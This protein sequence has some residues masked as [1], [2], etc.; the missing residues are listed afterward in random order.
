MRFI[1]ADLHKQ[2][3]TLCVVELVKGKTVI[4]DRPRFR[5]RDIDRIAEFLRAQG[6]CALVV[7]ST[8][9]YE[10]FVGLAEAIV[11]RVAVAHAA[12]LKIIAESTRKTDK[13]DAYVLAE[14][15]AKDM[16]PEAWFPTP[17][18]RQHR[19]LVR[20]AYK[21]KSRITSVKNTIRGILTRYNADRRDAFTRLGWEALQRVKMLDEDRWVLEDLREDLAELR[22][23]KQKV[24]K[25]LAE[26]AAQ[27]PQAE[28]EARAVLATMPGVGAVTID[29]LLA[30]LGDIRRFHSADAVASYAGL[31]PGVRSSAG[32]R[33]DLK[34]TK[35]GSPLLR[36]ILVQLA[37]RMK[38]TSARWRKKFEQ[39]SRRAG[40]KKATCAIARQLLLVLYA[41]LRDGQAY[42]LPAAA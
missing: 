29:V 5:C 6:P 10:W 21:V 28:R 23:R 19:T 24:E 18:V 20:R 16:L 32:K 14:F 40:K 7:E 25:R 36:W 9:G 41:M 8:I 12:K 34:L 3:I 31:D 30:E 42:H 11:D 17:R 15:L 1:G 38:R 13:I 4:L 39:I 27:A 35:A 22:Q 33:Y 37:H 26:F 2:S